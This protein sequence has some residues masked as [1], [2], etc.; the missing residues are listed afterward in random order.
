VE[1]IVGA[2]LLIGGFTLGHVTADRE[3]AETQASLEHEQT[4]SPFED[5]VIAQACRFG[6]DGPVSRDLTL[7]YIHER[8]DDA[9]GSAT[10]TGVCRRD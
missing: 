5:G 2:L 7:P 3:T 8:L 6:D 1:L 4:V 10:T 9:P